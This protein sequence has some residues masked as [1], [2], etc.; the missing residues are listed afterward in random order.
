[1]E[2]RENLG[3]QV[4]TKNVDG[5]TKGKTERRQLKRVG[6]EEIARKNWK[7]SESA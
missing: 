3:I 1:V 2:R 6:K 4:A 7:K 5:V